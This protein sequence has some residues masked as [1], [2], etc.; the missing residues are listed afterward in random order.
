MHHTPCFL[1]K[2]LTYPDTQQSITGPSFWFSP[3]RGVDRNAILDRCCIGNNYSDLISLGFKLGFCGTDLC[4]IKP[5][6]NVDD[7]HGMSPLMTGNLG[8]ESL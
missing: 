6:S 8:M 7:P 1:N 3:A 2:G 4:F 5:M